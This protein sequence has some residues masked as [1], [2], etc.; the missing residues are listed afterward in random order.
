MFL[1][2][3]NEY[4]LDYC[5]V[6]NTYFLPFTEIKVENPFD[7]AKHIYPIPKNITHRDEKLI[8]RILF[9]LNALHRLTVYVNF[10]GYYQWVPFV[11]ALEAILFYLPVV[12]WRGMYSASGNLHKLAATSAN[13]NSDHRKSVAGFR[14][15]GEGGLRHVRLSTEHRSGGS[16]EEYRDGGAFLDVH[17]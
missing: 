13:F 7:F 3:W 2:W 8:G 5:Y 1:G 9:S 16:A 14:G 11:L 17:E 12:I 4:A 10:L 15:E 6:Q